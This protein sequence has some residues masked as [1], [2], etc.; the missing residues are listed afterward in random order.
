MNNKQE[1]KTVTIKDFMWYLMFAAWDT[2]ISKFFLRF[3]FIEILFYNL[4]LLILILKWL[5]SSLIARPHVF[6]VSLLKVFV[7]SLVF[8]L[9]FLIILCCFLFILTLL[10]YFVVFYKWTFIFHRSALSIFGYVVN[11]LK[12]KVMMNSLWSMYSIKEKT[13]NKWRLTLSLLWF[14]VG[15][16]CSYDGDTDEVGHQILLNR[17]K[18]FHFHLHHPDI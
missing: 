14:D 2:H 15:L 18:H 17:N 4:C 5:K 8:D 10:C 7:L 12:T 9:W 6:E 11:Y 16:L 3:I 1:E 13:N